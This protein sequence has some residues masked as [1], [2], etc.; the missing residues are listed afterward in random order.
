MRWVRDG[1]EPGEALRNRFL[2]ARL[3][4]ARDQARFALE[5]AG[6]DGV[7]QRAEELF[8]YC[9]RKLGQGRDGIYGGGKAL[10]FQ[11]AE[12]CFFQVKSQQA[13]GDRTC[14][15]G[16]QVKVSCENREAL[17]VGSFDD[18][19]RAGVK[20]FRYERNEI[21]EAMR[22]DVLHDLGAVDS[23]EGL[24]G[25]GVEIREQV[26]LFG[27]Q[28]FCAAERDAFLDSDRCL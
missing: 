5:F 22:V 15:R 26:G 21:G 14:V 20:F 19:E 7:V 23:A 13:R 10:Y 2:R 11:A 4:K 8:A 18:G 25:E 27:M 3:G 1:E 24:I 12:S 6:D 9:L 28:A 17:R 16:I